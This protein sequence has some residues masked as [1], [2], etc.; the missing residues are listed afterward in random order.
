MLI[1]ECDDGSLRIG[2]AIPRAWLEHGKQ[3]EVRHAPSY[4]GPLDLDFTSRSDEQTLTARIELSGD[5]RPAVLLV[6]LRHPSGCRIQAVVVNGRP[7]TEYDPGQEWV[8]IAPVHEHTY[9][10]ETRYACAP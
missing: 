4:F 5:R 10:V 3:V 9:V 7:W 8:R 2:Q 1:H 6:R